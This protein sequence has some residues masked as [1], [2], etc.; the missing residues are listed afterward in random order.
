MARPEAFPMTS[1]KPLQGMGVWVILS[2]EIKDQDLE[3][4]GMED[5]MT[6]NPHKVILSNVVR[7]Q[8]PENK[9]TMTAHVEG[10]LPIFPDPPRLG[11]V[12]RPGALLILEM[13][14]EHLLHLRT[15]MLFLL[16]LRHTGKAHT[17]HL[18]GRV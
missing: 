13:V 18:L 14:G 12:D 8:R 2:K 4:E 9:A 15:Q 3:M 10:R 7:D 17:Q 11:L 5:L 1:T 16:I 6:G